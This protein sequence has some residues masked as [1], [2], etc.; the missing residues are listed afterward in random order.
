MLFIFIDRG[1]AFSGEAGNDP[2][3]IDSLSNPSPKSSF[4]KFFKTKG[5][6][7]KKNLINSVQEST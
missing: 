4:L 3:I 2:L 1:F 5:K 6:D 7:K